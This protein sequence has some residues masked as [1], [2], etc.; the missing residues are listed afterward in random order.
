LAQI[1]AYCETDDVNTY[2]VYVRF[3]RQRGLLDAA[4]SSAEEQ[5]VRAALGVLDAPH[6]REYLAAWPA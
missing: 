4:T 2:L 5:R 3:Q 1:R 6:W